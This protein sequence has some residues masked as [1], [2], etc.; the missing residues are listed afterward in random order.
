MTTVKDRF[1]KFSA[2]LPRL[3]QG[4][5]AGRWVVYLDGVQKDFDDSDVA[6]RWAVENYGLDAGYVVAKVVHEEPQWLTA[7]LAYGHT[8]WAAMGVEFYAGREKDAGDLALRGPIVAARL[9]ATEL[10]H[11]VHDVVW[12]QPTRREVPRLPV[13]PAAAVGTTRWR[14][15]HGAVLD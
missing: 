4:Q 14:S 7:A 10:P 2:E 12:R 6:Y 13:R 8:G 11:P 9:R 1:D 15:S 3:L 5:L